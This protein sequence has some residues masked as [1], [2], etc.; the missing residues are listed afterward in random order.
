MPTIWN[1]NRQL[2]SPLA[3]ALLVV[4]MVSGGACAGSSSSTND[5]VQAAYSGAMALLLTEGPD[6]AQA[7][8]DAAE[9]TSGESPLLMVGRAR[10]L[11]GRG[12]HDAALELLE[13]AA[14]LDPDL[15]EAQYFLSLSFFNSFRADESLAAAER[16][17]AL[18]PENV[19]HLYQVA[20]MYDRTGRPLVN[21]FQAQP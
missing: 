19:D 20:Q 14:E 21:R 8:L 10:V 9:A 17:V 1:C 11:S 16:A 7:A 15:A 2:F 5:G 18:D 4:V 3:A 6:A 13:Q 12:E